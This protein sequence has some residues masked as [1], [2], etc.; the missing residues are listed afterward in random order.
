M[1]TQD[2]PENRMGDGEDISAPRARQAYPGRRILWILSISLLLVV[3]ALFGAVALY[4]G[5][6]GR[7]NQPQADA[8]SARSFDTP[9]VETR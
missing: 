1:D 8:A 3:G 4:S 6:L 5:P 2:S 9:A 7:T